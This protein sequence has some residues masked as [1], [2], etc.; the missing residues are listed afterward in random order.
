MARLT[1]MQASSIGRRIRRII[2]RLCDETYVL[3]LNRPGGFSTLEL[4]IIKDHFVRGLSLRR[5]SANRHLGYYRVRRAAA[6]ARHLAAV[7]LASA[8]KP[9]R[10]PEESLS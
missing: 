4:A 2:A 3:C 8:P 10:A 5:I 6:K 1:G 9:R 7:Q